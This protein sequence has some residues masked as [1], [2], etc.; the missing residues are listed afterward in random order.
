MADPVGQETLE[1]VLRVQD[2]AS[3]AV[4][5]LGANTTKSMEQASESILEAGKVLDDYAKKTDSVMDRAQKAWDEK[6]HKEALGRAIERLRDLRDKDVPRL[7]DAFVKMGNRAQKGA[8]KIT[9]FLTQI[10]LQARSSTRSIQATGM[11]MLGAFSRGGFVGLAMAAATSGIGYIL[12]KHNEALE[13]IKRKQAEAL[14]QAKDTEAEVVLIARTGARE[15]ADAE[16]KLFAEQQKLLQAKAEAYGQE[17]DA[18]A[19]VE[20]K[21]TKE[22]RHEQQVR[23]NQLLVT[24]RKEQ[25]AVARTGGETLEQHKKNVEAIKAAR[26]DLAAHLEAQDAA[27]AVRRETEAIREQ[28]AYRTKLNAEMQAY[29]DRRWEEVTRL[30]AARSDG[31]ISLRKTLESQ[32]RLAQMTEEERKYADLVASARAAEAAGRKDLVAIAEK[33]LDYEKKFAKHQ[34]E[35][36]KHEVRQA[37]AESQETHVQKQLEL[38]KKKEGFERDSYRLRQEMQQLIK[39]GVDYAKVQALYEERFAELVKRRNQEENKYS[40]QLQKQIEH[41]KAILAGKEEEYLAQERINKAREEGGEKAVEQMKELI[42][43]EKQRTKEIEEQKKAD[44]ARQK[45]RRG[46]MVNAAGTHVDKGLARRRAARRRANRLRKYRRQAYMGRGLSEGDTGTIGGPISGRS[47]AE[48]GISGFSEWGWIRDEA[49]EEE[50]KKRAGVPHQVGTGE[51]DKGDKSKKPV[52]PEKPPSP[53]APITEDA[54]SATA[55]AAKELKDA[56]AA[57]DKLKTHA[58]TLEDDSKASTEATK[59]VE[60][61]FQEFSSQFGELA[62]QMKSMAQQ[63]D[64]AIAAHNKQIE[65]NKQALRELK[66]RLDEAVRL[67]GG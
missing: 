63:L 17:Y 37:K 54:A 39:D 41:Q 19:A 21:L 24:L 3:K 65:E 8:G 2:L 55:S 51:L 46:E 44:E 34:E 59:Q 66:Q 32:T 36:R 53:L 50:K 23:Y 11:E 13:E 28:A 64:P 33:L 25:E 16:D 35:K 57:L 48:Q 67:S 4:E 56:K 31:V 9:D 5:Q 49:T 38:L 18:V 20:R 14:Q 58:E 52:A 60:K 43:L 15:R 62:G 61:N 47:L 45:G 26:D 27:A 22:R 6:L 30:N 1:I 10:Q 29:A 12:A 40:T 7:G 42:E